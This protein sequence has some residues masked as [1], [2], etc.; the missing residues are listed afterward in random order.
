MDNPEQWV[1][2]CTS[3]H[4]IIWLYFIFLVN[5]CL[6]LMVEY[7]I[8]IITTWILFGG[9]VVWEGCWGVLRG[10]DNKDIDN[11]Q[12]RLFVREQVVCGRAYCYILKRGNSR[13]PKGLY[14]ARI[15][16]AKWLFFCWGG[17]FLV[18]LSRK[19]YCF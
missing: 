17:G 16:L 8:T 1:V 13:G 12:R 18:R 7:L 11:F 2:C 14:A 10:W 15:G 5:N 4:D 3:F 19:V 9:F 6:Y